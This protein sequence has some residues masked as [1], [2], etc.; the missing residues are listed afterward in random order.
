M[1]LLWAYYLHA[2]NICSMQVSLHIFGRLTEIQSNFNGKRLQGLN[3]GSNSCGGSFSNRGNVRAPI[4]FRRESQ[5]QHLKDD[6]SSTT[7]PSTFPLPTLNMPWIDRIALMLT[8]SML[9]FGW[10]KTLHQWTFT[11]H[12]K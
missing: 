3:Q 7:D 9:L 4:Q 10:Y 2:G 6:F 1:F 5:L 11:Q 12:I 8:S